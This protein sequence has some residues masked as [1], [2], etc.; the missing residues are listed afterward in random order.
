VRERVLRRRHAVGAEHLDALVEAV[1]RLARV[2]DRRQAPVLV[3]ERDE[4]RVDVAGVG[5]ARV[6]VDGAAGE[7]LHDLRPGDVA[8]HVEV[9]DRHVEEDP[10]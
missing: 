7:D 5:E 8:R 2:V 9:V 3:H 4:R 10:A 1:D 6:D